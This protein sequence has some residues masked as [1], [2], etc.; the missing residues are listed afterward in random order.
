MFD[1]AQPILQLSTYKINYG[2]LQTS[3]KQ[4]QTNIPTF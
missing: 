1:L 3:Y 2:N 4:K